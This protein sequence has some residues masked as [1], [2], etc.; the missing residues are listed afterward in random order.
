M[1]SDTGTVQYIVSLII[2]EKRHSDKTE[3]RGK[4]VGR[5]AAPKVLR[6]VFTRFGVGFR[7][8]PYAK[9]FNLKIRTY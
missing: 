8:H 7:N 6:K 4:A 3:R 1:L 5:N 2:E 9:E